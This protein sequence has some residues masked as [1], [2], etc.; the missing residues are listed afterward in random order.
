MKDIHM[1]YA[2]VISMIAV[3]CLCMVS[4]G[5]LDL[6]TLEEVDDAGDTTGNGNVLFRGFQ[7]E[8]GERTNNGD[9]VPLVKAVDGKNEVSVE[10][11]Y[12]I[13]RGADGSDLREN[14]TT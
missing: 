11:L 2:L 14:G 7:T 10:H 3:S 1:K 6:G 13:L 8:W 12:F 9:Y 5:C 4:M